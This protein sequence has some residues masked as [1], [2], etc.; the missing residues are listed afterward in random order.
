[1]QALF[2]QGERNKAEEKEEER[3]DSV[4][5]MR[6]MLM[7]HQPQLTPHHLVAAAACFPPSLA[8]VRLVT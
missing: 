5:M 3:C 4:Q 8:D 1:M 7:Q 6:E 2:L